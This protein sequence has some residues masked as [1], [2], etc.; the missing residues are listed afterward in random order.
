MWQ[1]VV[2]G[3][4]AQPHCD[5]DPDQHLSTVGWMD[6]AL[7]GPKWNLFLQSLVGRNQTEL[8]GALT[9]TPLNTF[10]TKWNADCEP[11]QRL[12]SEVW[13]KAF[14]EERR[15]SEQH[16]NVRGWGGWDFQLCVMFWYPHTFYILQYHCW[17]LPGRQNKPNKKK[18]DDMQWQ[19]KQYHR[20][21]LR[22]SDPHSPLCR[23]RSYRAW[24]TRRCH[25]HKGTWVACT[26]RTRRTLHRSGP[27]S[28]CP[29]RTPSSL[30][31]TCLRGLRR[32]DREAFSVLR[33]STPKN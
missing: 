17:H 28:R 33:H 25:W 18:K 6:V 29:R 15:L 2:K 10:K 1:K 12:A 26:Q 3:F 16:I 20:W 11:G 4:L 31:Y 19:N 7:K 24:G 30:W 5:P 13:W 8:Q 23:C 27:R 14:Q 22:P 9:S 32:T 21:L